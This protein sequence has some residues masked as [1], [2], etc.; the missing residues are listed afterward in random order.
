MAVVR[1]LVP[2]WHLID[3]GES[4]MLGGVYFAVLG[5]FSSEVVDN[6][7]EFSVFSAS[8]FG[9]DGRGGGRPLRRT[10]YGGK[11]S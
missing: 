1:P 10:Q 6:S 9:V 3:G 5:C 2:T 4:G 7:V 8:S 11:E